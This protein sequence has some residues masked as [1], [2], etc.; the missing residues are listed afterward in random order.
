MIG[1]TKQQQLVLAVV[2]ALLLVGWAV[3]IY[4]TANASPTTS[5]RQIP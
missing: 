4:R 2:L 5:V 3:K 1:L